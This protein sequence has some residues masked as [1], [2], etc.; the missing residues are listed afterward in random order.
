MKIAVIIPALN[1]EA[2]LAKTLSHVTPLGLDEIIVVDGGSQDQ[3]PA[4][5]ESYF[6]THTHITGHIISAPRGR[7]RQMNA[8]GWMAQSDILVFLHADTLLP[9][10]ARRAIEHALEQHYIGGR[11]DVRFEPDRGYGWLISRMMNWRSRWS[12]ICTGDQAIFVRKPIFRQLNGF[13]DIPLMEDIDFSYRAKRLGAIAPLREKVT[14]SFRRWEQ[15]G[16]LRTIVHMWT[17]RFL[18]WL[19]ISPHTLQQFY[20]AVR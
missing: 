1:E 12:G 15:N 17:L 11:F 9:K 6:Q 16:P 10:D 18:Y 5:A 13:S 20:G 3:T 4:I 19:G 2:T 14:T 7:A 8:G